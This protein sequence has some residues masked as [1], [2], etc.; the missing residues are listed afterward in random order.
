VLTIPLL[1]RPLAGRALKVS[2][3]PHGGSLSLAT[4][5]SSRSLGSP[6]TPALQRR[7]RR[8]LSSER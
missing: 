8:S 3:G 2:G 5:S 7:M 1:A 4:S 6:W